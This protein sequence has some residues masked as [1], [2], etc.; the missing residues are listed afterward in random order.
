ML[1]RCKECGGKGRITNRKE[2]SELVADLYCS[3]NDSE[4]GHTWVMTLAFG[5]SLSPSAKSA[6]KML[7]DLLRSKTPK[8]Q[9]AIL[10][11]ASLQF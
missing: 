4:C 1:V 8:E 2:Q 10:E 6:D 7:V 3:C 9:K 5:H 11:Q